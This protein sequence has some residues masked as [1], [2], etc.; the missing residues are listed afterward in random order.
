MNAKAGAAVVTKEEGAG[1]DWLRTLLPFAILIILIIVF[2]IGN[3]RFLSAGN[4]SNILRQTAVLLIVAMGGTYVILQGSIDLSVGS[5]VT[6]SGLM[7]ATALRD[8][9]LTSGLALIVGILVGLAC[10]AV[11]G[12]IFAYGKIPSF[13]T[14]LGMLSV[15]DGVGLLIT[16]GSPI[17]LTNTTFAWFSTGTLLG[18]LPNIGLWALIIYAIATWVGFRTKFGR[19]MFAIGGGERV[20]KL[21]GV[22]VDRYKFY[23]FL[24]CGMLAGLAGG[25][26]IGRIGAGVPAMGE[27]LLLDSIAAI[28]MGGTA[29]SGGVGGPHRTLLGVLVIGVLSNGMNVLGINP[30]VQM[31]IT[32]VVVILAVAVTLDRSK[33]TIMK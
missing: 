32:G 9:G 6:M 21:A 7:T 20:A 33:I 27:P 18:P 13:L 25:L 10:G 3:P 15:L 17:P 26:M 30:Y 22:K 23:A 1:R 2:S 11:N 5:I 31:S 19:Y 12:G 8:L 4:M 29:L 28:V 16:G 14:T 24:V